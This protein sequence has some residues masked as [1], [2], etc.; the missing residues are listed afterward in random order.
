MLYIAAKQE[1][2]EFVE[3]LLRTKAGKAVIN[4]FK[5][6]EKNNEHVPQSILQHGLTS[7]LANISNR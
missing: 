7:Y 1:A 2:S 6:E 4:S 3:D 5:D